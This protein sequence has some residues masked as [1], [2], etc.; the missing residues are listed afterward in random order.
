MSV[1]VSVI[2]GGLGAGLLFI[3]YWNKNKSDKEQVGFNRKAKLF[4]GVGV[5]L[6]VAAIVVLLVSLISGNASKSDNVTE[7]SETTSMKASKSILKIDKKTVTL[8]SGKAK[9]N[10]ELDKDTTLEIKSIKGRVD[11]IKYPAKNQAQKLNVSFVVAGEYELIAKQKDQMKT[12]KITVKKDPTLKSESAEENIN[13]ET[14]EPEI[15]EENT[16]VVDEATEQDVVNNEPTN[17]VAPQSNWAPQITEVVPNNNDQP[18]SEIQ[19][20][21]EVPSNES[22]SVEVPVDDKETNTNVNDGE[23]IESSDNQSKENM[24][25]KV[26]AQSASS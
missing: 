13:S 8:K 9:I 3:T 18:T 25:D 15:P 2:L 23:N 14:T 17:D 5:L 21:P 26:D 7:K 16:E 11:T 20:Q 6:I 4:G 22:E 24:T 1:V 10:V 19:P 12:E